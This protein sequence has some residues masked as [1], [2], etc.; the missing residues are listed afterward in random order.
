MQNKNNK[1]EVLGPRNFN[2]KHGH[3]HKID[4]GLTL[5]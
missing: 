3:D 2:I 4:I 1:S 5:T